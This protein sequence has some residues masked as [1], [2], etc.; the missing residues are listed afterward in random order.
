[1]V[2]NIETLLWVSVKSSNILASAY[3]KNILYVMF[4]NGGVYYYSDVE[5]SIFSQL[6]TAVSV[7]KFFHASIRSA[8]KYKSYDATFDVKHLKFISKD[9]YLKKLEDSS[10]E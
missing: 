10:L 4:K 5:E 8:Y 3:E 1:V 9:S 6:I 2:G 7:G